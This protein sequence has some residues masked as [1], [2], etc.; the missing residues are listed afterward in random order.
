MRKPSLKILGGLNATCE[1]F[2]ATLSEEILL[3]AAALANSDCLISV[4]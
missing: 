1:V 4:L 3:W 2:H